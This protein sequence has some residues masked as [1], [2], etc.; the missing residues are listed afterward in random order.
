MVKKT[1]TNGYVIIFAKWFRCLI[2]F[3]SYPISA[4]CKIH[5]FCNKLYFSL[6]RS[7]ITESGECTS[8]SCKSFSFEMSL[9]MGFYFSSEFLST[10]IAFSDQWYK[11]F[12]H[13]WKRKLLKTL[14][15][16]EKM[17]VTSIFSFSH[18]VF[19]SSQHKF[20]FLSQIYFV[21]CKCFEFGQA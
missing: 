16:K 12:Q 8:F 20:Q 4:S 11:P 6:S 21:V 15:E 13:L 19:Y 10:F 2:D 5:I 1:P 9:F 17:L 18:K 14:W 3:F 7:D